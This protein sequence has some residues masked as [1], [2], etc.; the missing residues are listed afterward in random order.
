MKQPITFR[1]IYTAKVVDMCYSPA[2]VDEQEVTSAEFS[3]ISRGA[4]G[5]WS[6]KRGDPIRCRSRKKTHKVWRGESYS[7][8]HWQMCEK[9]VHFGPR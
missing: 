4:A 8:S 9:V 3:E 6:Y 2:V 7:V 1:R 5:L